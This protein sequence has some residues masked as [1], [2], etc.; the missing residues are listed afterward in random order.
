MSEIIDY[1]LEGVDEVVN[2]LGDLPDTVKQKIVKG[3]LNK[4]GK[5]FIV[6]PLRT[7]LNYSESTL[8]SIKVVKQ[9]DPNGVAVAAG[10]TSKGFHLRWADLGTKIRKTKKG[11]NRGAITGKKQIQ[12]IIE[13]SIEHIVDYTNEEFGN[14]VDKMLQRRLKKYRKL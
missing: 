2:A 1:K 11:W 10:V 6:E 3:F 12:P 13:D 5:K 14:E 4:V 9:E 8:R 7:S